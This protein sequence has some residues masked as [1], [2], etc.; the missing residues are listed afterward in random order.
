VHSLRGYIAVCFASTVVLFAAVA[1]VAL[2][3]VRARD[4][5]RSE[6]STRLRPAQ[7]AVGE[8]TQRLLDREAGIRAFDLADQSSP[9]QLV[10]S[11]ITSE[12][13]LL[14]ELHNELATS[15]RASAALQKAAAAIASWNTK[16]TGPA[17]AR[18]LL[19]TALARLAALDGAVS[20]AIATQSARGNAAGNHLVWI[21][22]IVLALLLLLSIGL[23]VLLRRQITKPLEVLGARVAAAGSGNLEQPIPQVGASELSTLATA[24]DQM[25]RRLL[26]QASDTLQ[27]S[28]ITAQD[29][30]RRRIAQD[31]HDD[32]VQSLT[33]VSLHLQRLGRRLS[34]PEQNRMVREAE[35]ATTHAIARLRRLM[36]E[37]HPAGLE[38]EGL[39][40]ALRAYFAET[41]DPASVQWNVDTSLKQEPSP[42]VQSLA[43]RLAREAVLNALKHAHPTRVRVALVE[44]NDG[45]GAVITDNGNGFDPDAI[46]ESPGHMGLSTTTAMAT[47]AGGWWKVLSHP[48]TGTTVQFWLPDRS[49]AATELHNTVV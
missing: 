34:E 24:V 11:A 12:T 16:P 35:I 36:F 23:Y 29:E 28:L 10:A 14:R 45:V 47:A 31:I 32:S 40:A 4:A 26:E 7:T 46:R 18:H 49:L 6:L 3:T 13:S 43:Y 38:R 42:S 48:R 39:A 41:I 9:R 5:A 2:T 20:S 37:L 30:E 21:V 27:R 19:D 33:V 22:W 1:G 15:P 17:N 8:L 44:R 25:R